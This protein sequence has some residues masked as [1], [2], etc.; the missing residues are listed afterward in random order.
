MSSTMKDIAKLAGVSQQ[1]V[2]AV[3]NGA[4]TIRISASTRQRVLDAAHRLSYVPNRLSSALR[5]KSSGLLALVLPWNNPELM[6]SVEQEA[7]RHG[8]K[9]LTLFSTYPGTDRER[10][11]IE[12]VLGWHVDGLIWLPYA[13]DDDYYSY[14]PGILEKNSTQVLFL[15]R[16]LPGFTA[17]FIGT[18]YFS[19]I[20]RVVEHLLECGFTDLCYIAYN[21][22]FPLKHQ[23][24]A[25]F[26]S[27]VGASGRV[28]SVDA[29]DSANIQELLPALNF[30]GVGIICDSD[31][32][33][34]LLIDELRKRDIQ[35]GTDCGVVS[36][37][38]HKVLEIMF[39]GELVRPTLT[40]VRQNS[41]VQ[42]E[43]AARILLNR[44]QN[45]A[46]PT[47][48]ILLEMPFTIRNSTV[49]ESKKKKKEN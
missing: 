28:L 47:S 19:G 32:I 3:F 45:P 9:L 25:Y 31:S 48:D 44:V 36:I 43:L 10:A 24:P 49:Q 13:K 29:Q 41:S 38:D 16:R 21:S 2:S 15:Q 33:A 1:A 17:D 18:D 46:I 35:T 42:G 27:I 7:Y 34:V 5:T 4:K 23:R 20:R 26:Q 22:S 6:E 11:A 12:A 14:L 40:S 30:P 39:V 8:F 37:G